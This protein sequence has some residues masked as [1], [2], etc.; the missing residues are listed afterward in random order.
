MEKIKINCGVCNG[1]SK[2][3]VELFRTIM[4]KIRELWPDIEKTGSHTG[5]WSSTEWNNSEVS[6]KYEVDSSD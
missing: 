1:H 5:C 4:D 3:Q 6:F 2:K